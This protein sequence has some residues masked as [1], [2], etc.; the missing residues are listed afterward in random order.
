MPVLTVSETPRTGTRLAEHPSVR[1][2]R[3]HPFAAAMIISVFLGLLS[4]IVWPTI[5]SYDPFSWVVWGHEVSDPNIPFYVGNG[6]SWKPLPFFFTTIY[7]L[8]GTAAPWLWVV[9]ARIGGFA[10][11]TGAV[12]LTLLISRRAGLPAWAGWVGGLVAIAGIVLT[13]SESLWTY[14][15]FRGTSEV[16]LIGVWLWSIERLITRHHWQAYMLMAAEGL[17]RPEAWP[18][19]LV[20]GAYLFWKH[21]GMR[22]WV[23]LALIAQPVGWFV[24]PWISTGQP[25]L[26]ATHASLYNG[27]LG[28]N[29]LATLLSRGESLQ[30]LPT[31]GLAI[32]AVGIGLWKGRGFLRALAGRWRTPN[33]VIARIASEASEVPIVLGLGIGALGWWVVVIFETADHYPGLQRF[34]LPGSVM[35]CVLSG[36]GLVQIATW[37]GRLVPGRASLAGLLVAA[38]MCVGSWHWFAQRWTWARAE[39][40]LAATAVTRIDALGRSVTVLGGLKKILPCAGSVITINHSLQTAMA[41]ELGTDLAKVQTVLTKPGLAWVGPWD[42]IDGG[43]PPIAFKFSTHTVATVGPWSIQQVFPYHG[44]PNACV[45]A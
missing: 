35:I 18:F 36:Y 6:P 37:I 13:W 21:P 12:R 41:W 26:A 7:G 24:P 29:W 16:L 42:S 31:L 14:Y 15:F 28:P 25:F 2:G 34:F 17:M 33:A 9:T 3:E 45:G 32:L 20:Y 8:F 30:S 22:I 43:P 38:I 19:M 1:W 39:E 5:P 11:L 10:G 23:V 4:G 40:P 44:K 27:Q